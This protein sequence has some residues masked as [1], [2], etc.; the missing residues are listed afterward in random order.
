MHTEVVKLACNVLVPESNDPEGDAQSIV[1][2]AL[3]E[4]ADERI[5]LVKSEHEEVVLEV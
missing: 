2:S 3:L 5:Y 4:A 1:V